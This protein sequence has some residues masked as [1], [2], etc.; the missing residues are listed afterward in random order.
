MENHKMCFGEIVWF[1]APKG[2]GFIAWVDENGA[3]QKD[4][5]CHY[6]D[7]IMPQGGYKTLNKGQKVSFK[8]GKNLRGQDKAIEIAPIL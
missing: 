4:I 8:I 2:Y 5:F 6:S 7:I 3:P 1:S